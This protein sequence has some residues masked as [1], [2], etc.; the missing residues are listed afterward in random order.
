MHLHLELYQ[1]VRQLNVMFGI[2][3]TMEL[4]AYMIL[5]IRLSNYIYL[6]IKTKG[7][8]IVTSLDWLYLS[9]WIFL[10]VA[11]IFFFNYICETVSAKSNKIKGV[12]HQLTD[13]HQ[14]TDIR[15][16]IHQFTLQMIYH[17]LKLTGLGLFYF[18]NSFLRKFVITIATFI[19]IIMQMS[20]IPFIAQ[21]AIW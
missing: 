16:E 9:Y 20:P 8:F 1:I 3:I 6:H 14:Y 19:I 13:L 21:G 4:G 5:I 12:L 10:H 18:G 7:R 17:P 11:K 2:Q 15:D